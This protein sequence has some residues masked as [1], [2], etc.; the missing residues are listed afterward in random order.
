MRI[1]IEGWDPVDRQPVRG[2]LLG[3][4]RAQ[5]Q[6][7]D[8]VTVTVSAAE[9][10]QPGSSH[11][12]RANGSSDALLTVVMKQNPMLLQKTAPG[13]VRVGACVWDSGYIMCALLED[14]VRR[15]A[16]GLSGARCV[17]LGAGCGLVGLVAARLGASVMLTGKP[18]GALCMADAEQGG[19]NYLV[20]C[21][22][23]PQGS[24]VH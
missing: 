7:A 15:R 12:G 9:D 23:H 19:K 20:H 5:T 8:L 11:G 1:T 3:V 24:Q 6:A 16:L 18:A 14:R 17:E 4:D 22:S 13:G 10:A 2:E 21:N